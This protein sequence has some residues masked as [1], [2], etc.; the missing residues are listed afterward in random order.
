V[1]LW[2]AYGIAATNPRFPIK[3]IGILDGDQQV[4]SG[5]IKFPGTYGPE[6]QIFTDI[7]ANAIPEL[8]SRLGLSKEALTTAFNQ[9]ITAVDSHDWTGHL[10]RITG[11]TIPYL[12]ETM[13]QVWVRHCVAA[14]ELE[15]FCTAVKNMLT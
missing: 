3:S 15:S 9:A 14:D 2:S 1:G 10:A 7:Q 12:W 13:S 11:Q 8:A 5:S 4:Q 6:K